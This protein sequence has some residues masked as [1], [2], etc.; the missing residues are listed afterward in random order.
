M[1]ARSL[2]PANLFPLPQLVS[3]FSVGTPT[4]TESST[5]IM[6]EIRAPGVI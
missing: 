2:E 6:A 4:K 3:A 5:S 1:A